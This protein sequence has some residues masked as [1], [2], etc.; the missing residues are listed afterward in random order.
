[1]ECLILGN[2]SDECIQVLLLALG[3]PVLSPIPTFVMYELTSKALGLRF[4]GIPLGPRFELPLDL[5][6]ETIRRERPR[7]IFLASPNNPTGNTFS[8]EEI[9][10]V[11]EAS[12]GLVVVDEAYY[13][14][15]GRTVLP[16]AS[17]YEN[18]AILRTLSKIGLAGIRV[19]YLVAHEALIEEL[20]KV[21]LPYNVNA[22]S[23]A[24]ARFA[25]EHEEAIHAQV[26]VIIEERERLFRA[27]SE[28]SEL[29][30]FPSEANFLLFRTRIPVDPIYRGLIVEGVLVRNLSNGPGLANCLRVT[31]GTPEEN[32]LFLEMLRKILG[33]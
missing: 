7:L 5:V 20:N 21:R 16:H 31:V 3:G 4:L 10:K 30:V 22:L 11:V 6:L 25:L 18:L 33:P 13:P 32:D 28:L 19:G 9:L 8:E 2:G 23:Q 12:E 1:M 27:L 14:Y 24:A 17:R 15:A 29:E 26:E